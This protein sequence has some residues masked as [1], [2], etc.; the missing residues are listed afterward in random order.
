[1][2]KSVARDKCPRV[3]SISIYCRTA[4]S[5][6][7]S[8]VPPCLPSPPPYRALILCPSCHKRR[9]PASANNPAT[10]G[11]VPPQIFLHEPHVGGALR[12]R[13]AACGRAGLGAGGGAAFPLGRAK[14]GRSKQSLHLLSIPNLI[15]I[16]ILTPI[17]IITIHVA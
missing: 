12:G 14:D 9:V 4:A 10:S 3:G 15:L 11:T 13:V 6:S 17:N 5:F 2:R 8:L 16:L 1:M 7:P